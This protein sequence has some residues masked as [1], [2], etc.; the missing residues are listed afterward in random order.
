MNIDEINKLLQTEFFYTSDILEEVKEK[1]LAAAL[2]V[3]TRWRDAKGSINQEDRSLNHL[4][5]VGCIGSPW[6]WECGVAFDTTPYS[7]Y[8]SKDFNPDET[9][10]PVSEFCLSLCKAESGLSK[11]VPKK[12]IKLSL[13]WDE[14]KREAKLVGV[15]LKG[16]KRRKESK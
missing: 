14:V 3:Y 15:S 7:I 2:L 8:T 6:Y 4:R 11:H 1:R 12:S 10:C 5:C 16:V 13:A 9:I